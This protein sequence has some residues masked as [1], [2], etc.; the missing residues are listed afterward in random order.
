[1]VLLPVTGLFEAKQIAKKLT[2]KVAERSFAIKDLLQLKLTISI[3]V[4]QWI[5][6]ESICIET[7]ERADK[8]LY[9]AKSA[10]KN[11]V[12]VADFTDIT[13]SPNSSSQSKKA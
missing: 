11:A 1:V 9:L 13:L 2:K 5:G 4:A 10:G 7:L 3:G 12:V 8:A 6:G